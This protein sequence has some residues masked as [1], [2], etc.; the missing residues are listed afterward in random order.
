MRIFAKSFA[1]RSLLAQSRGRSAFG[2]L[3]FLIVIGAVGYV[4]FKF[5]EAGWEYMDVRQK[6]REALNWAVANNAKTDAEMV[7]RISKDVR[8]AGLE[9]GPEASGSLTPERN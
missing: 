2:C 4:G 7:Q 9:L 3:V 1:Q 8:E 5:G 6:V